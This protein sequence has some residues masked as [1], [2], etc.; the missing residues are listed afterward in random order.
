MFGMM[1]KESGMVSP[2]VNSQIN[3]Q[4]IIQAYESGV[5]STEGTL[6]LIAGDASD[7]KF[8]RL[9]SPKLNA[10]CMKFPKWEGGYGG[11]PMSWLGMQSALV[12]IGIPVPRILFVDEKNSCIW[13]EDFGDNFLNFRLGNRTLDETDPECKTTLNL[14]RDA[15]ELL[16]QVQY[17]RSHLLNH[18]AQDR[19]FDF[20]KLFFEMNFFVT[21]FIKGWL[22]LPFASE[23][24]NTQEIVRE[25]ESLCTLLHGCERVLCHRDYHVRNVMVV[26]GNV[27]WIDFQDARMGPH[28]YDVVSLLRDSYIRITPG[29]R[30]SLLKYYG[31]K[32]NEVRKREGKTPLSNEALFHEA[33]LM[34]LQRNIKALGSFGY[35]ATQKQKTGYLKYVRHTIETILADDFSRESGMR[36]ADAF[37]ATIGFL[38][39]LLHGEGQDKL[40]SRFRAFGVLDTF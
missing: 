36:I 15:L 9:E 31:T 32:L 8:F 2:D 4:A 18:P 3:F 12:G 11:D 17:P 25:L 26:G 27:R 29:T 13:T 20:E 14:Y 16:V 23:D 28:T 34:G 24:K 30:D 35:L 37:P 1:N 22:G 10:I 39:D 7:R 40:T 5:P 19:A 6:S 38:Q 21:H 33:S